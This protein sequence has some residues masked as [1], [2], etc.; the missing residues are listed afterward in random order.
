MEG[1][2]ARYK[3]REGGGKYKAHGIVAGTVHPTHHTLSIVH[4][5][6]VGRRWGEAILNQM[7]H[8]RQR[9]IENKLATS[10]KPAREGHRTRTTPTEQQGN[11]VHSVQTQGGGRGQGGCVERD[12]P[13]AS[14]RGRASIPVGV[15]HVA[16]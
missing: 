10:S 9:G 13:C 14:A 8:C 6:S 11:G 5:V 4:P 16:S 1:E 15:R 12:R 7:G 3:G 2:G